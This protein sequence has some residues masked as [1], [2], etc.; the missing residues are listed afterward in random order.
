MKFCSNCGA[1]VTLR[2]PDGDDRE[3]HVCPACNIIHYSNPTIIAG[4]LPIYGDQVLL[5]KRA[6]EP[7][8]G[9]WTLPAGFMENGESVEE[10]A[11]RECWEEAETKLRLDGL[12]T[13]FS[14]PEIN[15]V[16]ML[17]KG[18]VLN[19]E[20]GVGPESLETQLYSEEDIPWSE[21][22]FPVIRRTL[23][24]YFSDRK[25]GHFP[26]RSEALYRHVKR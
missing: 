9:M 4:A 5:C 14:L 8:Y 26:L 15:Q 10:G 18:E 2:I 20:Y 17:F 7:C 6:I 12:Y 23:Q 16:Y 19:G 11:L 22:A 25:T 21:L 24:H 1:N 3:R 13:V